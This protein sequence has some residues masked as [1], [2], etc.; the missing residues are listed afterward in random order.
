ME[1]YD[2]SLVLGERILSL[3]PKPRGKAAISLDALTRHACVLGTTGSGKSTC[4]GVIALELD[5]LKIPAVIL[6]RTGEYVGMLSTI[7]PR[8]LK[9]GTNLVISPFDPRDT[10]AYKHVEEWISLL[11]HFSHVSHGVGLSPLQYRV[12]R[13]VFDAYFRGTRRPLAIHELIV[14]L[15]DQE[16]EF[17]ELRGWPESIEALI[18]KLWPLTHGEV[19]KTINTY[20]RRFEVAAL[21]EPGVTVIDLSVLPDDRSKNMLSQIIMKEVYEETKK[22]GMHDSVRLVMILDEA[23][24][25]A[26]VEKGYISMPEKFAMELR[27]YGFALVTCA[28]RPSLISQNVIAN[29]NTLVCHM[30]NNELDIEA[31]AGFFVGSS[32]KDSLR[33]LPVGVAMVQV[34]HPEPKDALRVVIGTADQRSVLVSGRHGTMGME[35]DRSIHTGPMNAMQTS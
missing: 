32:I 26:P 11:D 20:S 12:L 8:V 29:S 6:D 33:K 18:S 25:L 22:R 7:R 4:A 35:P 19:G 34:N 24:N 10:Y 1:I 17:A 31:A 9:P 13:E 27:K 14:R 2:A 21:F 30:L 15:E 16:R 23:Q 28:S 3:D 5:R